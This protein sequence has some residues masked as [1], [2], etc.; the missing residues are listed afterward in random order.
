MSNRVYNIEISAQNSLVTVTTK[1]EILI[2]MFKLSTMF[3]S[4]YGLQ[5]DIFLDYEEANIW[6]EDPDSIKLH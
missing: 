4:K 3:I 6:L 2:N 5:T 1:G